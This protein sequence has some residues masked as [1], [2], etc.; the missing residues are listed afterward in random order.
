VWSIDEYLDKI[1]IHEYFVVKCAVPRKSAETA[2]GGSH[3]L[4][5]LVCLFIKKKLHDALTDKVY[6]SLYHK[7][8]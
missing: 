3:P 7:L 6:D 4:S 8:I 2:S 1:V 5:L